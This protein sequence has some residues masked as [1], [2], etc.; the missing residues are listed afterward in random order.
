[1]GFLDSIFGGKSKLSGP[2]PD[3]LFAMTTAQVH[4]ET[5][6]N[7]KHRQTAGIVFQALGTADFSA[8]LSEAEEL[9]R[10]TAEETG[11]TLRSTDDEFGYRWLVLEDPDF[12]DL[13]VSLNTVSNELQ[14]GGYGDRL[15]ACV[16][17]FEEGAASPGDDRA[18]PA[19]PAASPKGRRVYLIYNFKRGS[20]YPFVPAGEKSRDTE[21]ELRL[22]AQI[23][24]ELPIEADTA[25]WFPLWEIPL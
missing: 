7:M 24:S 5:A 9:L 12:E 11:T 18:Q 2:A 19:E 20:F 13:V 23:G 22:K 25:R 14:G 15:L 1:M 17:A 3:R 21:R 10:G 16:F 8:I 6:L 4:L